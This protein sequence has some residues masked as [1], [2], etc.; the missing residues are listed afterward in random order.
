MSDSTLALSLPET[1]LI[2]TGPDRKYAKDRQIYTPE[3]L[4]HRLGVGVRGTQQPGL[5]VLITV[6]TV[7]IGV[8][9]NQYHWG[10][11]ACRLLALKALYV[12]EDDISRALLNESITTTMLR[13]AL[14]SADA[15]GLHDLT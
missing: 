12:H 4:V 11:E 9:N 5:A 6:V 14:A 1:L 15:E 3:A 10:N 13:E 8:L 7:L 2:L